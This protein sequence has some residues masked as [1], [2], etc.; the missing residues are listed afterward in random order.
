MHMHSA[1][2][3]QHPEWI[4]DYLFSAYIYPSP[5]SLSALLSYLFPEHAQAFYGAYLEPL[6]AKADVR[7]VKPFL[8][9]P[10]AVLP[11]VVTGDV[12]IAFGFGTFCLLTS[13]S[14]VLAMVLALLG[15]VGL[16]RMERFYTAC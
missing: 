2:A 5:H 6:L 3:S 10:I 8:A 14:S 15:Y 1:V 4:A 16:K 11:A 9:Y 12:F 7:A 13:P